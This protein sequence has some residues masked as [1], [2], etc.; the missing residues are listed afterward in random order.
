MTTP[1]RI[2]ITHQRPMTIPTIRA[3][4]ERLVA[5][6]KPKYTDPEEIVEAASAVLA[7]RTA[8]NAEPEA[9]NSDDAIDRWIES[10]PGWPDDWP[11]V[12]QSQLTALIG[13]ALEH[14]GRPTPQPP[15]PTIQDANRLAPGCPDE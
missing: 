14:W 3:A 7:A 6:V 15:H 5:A 10:R 13:E 12:T 8:L 1:D 9:D 4:L 11:A 2:T